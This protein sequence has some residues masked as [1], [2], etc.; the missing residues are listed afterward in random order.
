MCWVAFRKFP[1]VTALL[2]SITL[3]GETVLQCHSSKSST[4]SSSTNSTHNVSDCG[5]KVPSMNQGAIELVVQNIPRIW[6]RDADLWAEADEL[7]GPNVIQNR[8][9]PTS[10]ENWNPQSTNDGKLEVFGITSMRNYIKLQL[11]K[12]KSPVLRIG[13]FG[14]NLT[15]HFDDKAPPPKHRNS[16]RRFFRQDV[17]AKGEDKRITY[18]MLDGEFFKLFR[19]KSINFSRFR[20]IQAM[21][22]T[23][24]NSRVARDELGISSSP[25]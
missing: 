11:P 5:K 7:T 2:S 23:V 15:L 16:F 17:P 14:G 10:A 8:T 25:Q 13:Q 12:R 21:A 24:E 4:G 22:G 18:I 19:P 1:S 9:G 3:D 6:S 20:Q